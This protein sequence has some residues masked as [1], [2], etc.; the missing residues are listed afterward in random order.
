MQDN[1][2]GMFLYLF[3]LFFP[4]SAVPSKPVLFGFAL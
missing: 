1:T 4:D 3:T 2:N